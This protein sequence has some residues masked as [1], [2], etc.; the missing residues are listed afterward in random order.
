MQLEGAGGSDG[1]DMFGSTV[2]LM[3]ATI[4]ENNND[5]QGAG[6]FLAGP[7]ALVILVSDG[8]GNCPTIQRNGAAGVFAQN[9]GAVVRARC[10][11]IPTVW[12]RLMA[13]ILTSAGPC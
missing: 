10:A 9:G 7:N 12:P 3:G 2:R 1:I 6:V 5:A 4:I 8:S 11:T 13:P